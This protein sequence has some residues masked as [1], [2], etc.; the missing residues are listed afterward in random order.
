MNL[1]AKKHRELVLVMAGGRGTRFW[2][3]S[4]ESRPKQF[5]TMIGNESLLQQTVRRLSGRFQ[6][7]NI[8]V[9]TT[10]QLSEETKKLLPDIPGENV[11]VEPEGRNTAPC[12]ALALVM[13]EQ[14]I[15][16]GVMVVLSADAWIG[17]ETKFLNDL[18]QA[19]VH[20]AEKH[21]LVT[22]GISPSYP[23]TGY[24]YI[25]TYEANTEGALLKVK[26][27]KEKPS[28]KKATEYLEAGNY[29]WNAGMFIW[30]LGDFRTQL[31]EHCPE[32]IKPLDDWIN[33][34]A[35]PADL[36]RVY[37]GLPKVSIDHALMEKAKKVATLPASF[38]WSDVGSWSAMVDF[39]EADSS[40]N[41]VVGD[42]LIS[43]SSNCAIFGGQRFIAVN[44][45]SNLIVVDESDAL[46]ICHKGST[47]DVRSIVDKI[48]VLGRN[49]LL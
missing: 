33:A 31:L 38:R 42:V 5:L 20:A 8:F 3:R 36:P 30:T 21:D 16:D 14:L 27:F 18:D 19:V 15:S 24:G 7:E 45:L 10:K 29:Y 37:R 2:P 40:N 49:D 25:E 6:P 46:L 41:V 13:I 4:R 22:L 9:L 43:E 11:L 35:K 28:Y 26:S 39:Y 32:V 17:D 47:Q 23:E 1:L 34:G 48:R 44:G 12:L